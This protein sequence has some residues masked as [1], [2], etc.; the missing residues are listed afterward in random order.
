MLA[1]PNHW[2]PCL[3]KEFLAADEIC[4]ALGTTFDF[5]HQ[6]PWDSTNVSL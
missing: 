2:F 3:K 5:Q 6:L 1:F 4:A